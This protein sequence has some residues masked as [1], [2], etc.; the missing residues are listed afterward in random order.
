MALVSYFVLN[1]IY[2]INTIIFV[3]T[4][5][6]AIGWMHIYLHASIMNDIGAT[7]DDPI[8]KFFNKKLAE[9]CYVDSI[10]RSATWVD[11][12][13]DNIIKTIENKQNDAN[14]RI[15]GLYKMYDNRNKE[16]ASAYA[17]RIEDKNKTL[18]ELQTVVEEIKTGFSDNEK[19]T[20]QF[21]NDYRDVIKENVSKLQNLAI[22]IVNKLNRNIY[23]KKYGEKRK[24]Y[25]KSYEKINGYIKKL[26]RDRF[27]ETEISELPE[28]PIEAKKG[29]A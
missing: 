15:L 11:K 3:G 18:A 6:I 26:N 23:T 25:V 4:F 9:R 27:L 10:S 16:R 2:I 13:L 29:K 22:E 12:N 28:I 1:Q 19:N 24:M 20:S 5:L 8:A 7:C 21:I 14:T 17:Q